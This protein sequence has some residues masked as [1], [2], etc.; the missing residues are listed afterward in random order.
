[1]ER[2]VQSNKSNINPYIEAIKE[3]GYKNI[4]ITFD[5]SSNSGDSEYINSNSGNLEYQ[6]TRTNEAGVNNNTKNN[7]T[8]IIENIMKCHIWK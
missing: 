3:Y 2:C 5:D 1:M 4:V 6:N 8:I 7:G